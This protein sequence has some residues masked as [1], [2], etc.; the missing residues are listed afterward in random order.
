MASC[1]DVNFKFVTWVVA[2]RGKAIGVMV[3]SG[4]GE[5]DGRITA[6]AR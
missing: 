6:L 1:V 4:P 2:N 5:V 3:Q